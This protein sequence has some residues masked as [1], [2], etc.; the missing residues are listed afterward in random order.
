MPKLDFTFLI[1]QV[2]GLCVIPLS[3][4]LG[5]MLGGIIMSCVVV[6]FVLSFFF[7]RLYLRQQET[8]I[9]KSSVMSVEDL[10]IENEVYTDKD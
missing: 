5:L 8:A 9:D 2:A 7:E 3:L 4:E 1:F 10:G 6:F